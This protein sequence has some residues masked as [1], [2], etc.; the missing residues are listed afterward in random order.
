MVCFPCSCVKW[1]QKAKAN[2]DS[3]EGE[4]VPDGRGPAGQ[5]GAPAPG[6]NTPPASPCLWGPAFPQHSLHGSNCF[7]DQWSVLTFHDAP[8]FKHVTDT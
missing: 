8:T 2:E 5:A 4:L 3:K 7:L 6:L 1:Q